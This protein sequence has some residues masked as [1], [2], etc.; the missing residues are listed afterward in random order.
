MSLERQKHSQ[1]QRCSA[2][3]SSVYLSFLL[4]LCPA[5]GAAGDCIDASGLTSAV[6]SITRNFDSEEK[7]ASKGI[8]AI[9]GTAWFL[10]ATSIVTADHVAEA[11]KL[12]REAWKLIEISDGKKRQVVPIRILRVAGPRAE[13]IAVLEL[14]AASPAARTLEPRMQPLAPEE[15]VVSLAY[16]GNRQ[17]LATGR[18]VEFGENGRFTGTALFE[19]YDGEDRLVLDHGASGAPVVDCAGR[20]V[21]VVTNL[22]VQTLPFPFRQIR[23]STAWGQANVLAV[24]IHVLSSLAQAIEGLSAAIQQDR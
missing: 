9:R 4:V 23:M 14:R 6:V 16:P 2:W 12:S 1:R 10:S 3:V 15:Q 8:L 24:P 19:M 18:F 5:P 22:F 20:V 7:E 11:M 13:K 21:A 17:R